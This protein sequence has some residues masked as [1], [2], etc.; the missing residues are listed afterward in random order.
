MYRSKPDIYEM[1][2]TLTLEMKEE[3]VEYLKADIAAAKVAPK[4]SYLEK[5]WTEIKRLIEVLKYEPYIDDQF[6]IEEI[7]IMCEK[8]IKSGKLKKEPWEIRRRV[9]KSIIG[10]EY[11]DYYGVCDPMRDL[12]RALMF[13][14]EEKIEVAEIIFEIGSEYMQADGAKLYKECGQLDKYIAYVEQH[15]KDEEE[16]YIEVIDY[17]KDSDPIK[18]VETAE[19]GLKK[20]KK[21]QTGIMIFL[22]QNAR[23]N[24]DK[25]QEAKF[26]KSAKLRYAVDYAK[27]KEALGL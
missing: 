9:I 8:M 7:W 4:K 13:T 19:L 17:Y 18:A 24:G 2:D 23:E 14:T 16:P 26:I 22:I 6:E 25:E 1:L 15:L 5:Q 11:Y 10:G 21:K 12:F 20:C 27:V 3:L